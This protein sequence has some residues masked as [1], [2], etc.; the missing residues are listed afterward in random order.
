[1]LEEASE[2]EIQNVPNDQFGIYLNEYALAK[3]TSFVPSELANT[4]SIMT[5]DRRV[6]VSNIF[7]P[8]ALNNQVDSNK[9]T[10]KK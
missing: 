7:E 8:E 2:I 10:L 6:E 4:E 9:K 5:G 1:M 3:K